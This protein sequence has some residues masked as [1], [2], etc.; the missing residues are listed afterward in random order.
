MCA[1]KYCTQR[2]LCC[3]ILEAVL[4]EGRFLLLLA[5]HPDVET[6]AFSECSH[7]FIWLVPLIC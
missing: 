7:A 4:E 2:T 1:T 6:A 3:I 5:M